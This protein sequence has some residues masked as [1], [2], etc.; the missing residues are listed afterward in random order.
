MDSMH[1]VRVDH[2]RNRIYIQC[3]RALLFEMSHVLHS[4]IDMT[5]IVR[6]RQVIA[7]QQEQ[8]RAAPARRKN[9]R[10]A[11]TRA[12]GVHALYLR[13]LNN[14]CGGDKAAAI[15]VTAAELNML[16]V[17]VRGFLQ[18][19]RQAQKEAAHA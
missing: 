2:R 18:M 14:G 1:A 17:D 10:A 11:I 8:K 9:A 12:A 3:D 5:R 13:H 7:Y 19:H 6:N 15:R 4:L 16:H